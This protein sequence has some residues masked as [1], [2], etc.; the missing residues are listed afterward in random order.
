VPGLRD[1]A[2][3]DLAASDRL[4]V[5]LTVAQARALARAASLAELLFDPA[6]G[7][8]PAG[9]GGEVRPLQAGQMALEIAVIAGGY[10]L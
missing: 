6:A 3:I 7:T 8:L 4:T 2:M 10:E 5:R 1:G 9:D